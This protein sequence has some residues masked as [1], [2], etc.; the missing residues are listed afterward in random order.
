MTFLTYLGFSLILIGLPLGM[1]TFR[2]TVE[3]DDGSM[4]LFVV[5]VVMCLGGIW[6]LTT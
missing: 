4:V 1:F 2:G 3:G 5:A 6:A